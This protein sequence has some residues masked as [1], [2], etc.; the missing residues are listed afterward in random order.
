MPPLL[1]YHIQ[2]GP[3]DDH[4]I[5]RSQLI[6]SQ[7]PDIERMPDEPVFFREVRYSLPFIREDEKRH[8][9]VDTPTVSA[10][11]GDSRAQDAAPFFIECMLVCIWFHVVEHLHYDVRRGEYK[12]LS[13]T[14]FMEHVGKRQG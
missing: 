3:L 14:G 9:I 4:P 7:L 5:G 6:G 8:A 1:V 10:K 13:R 2:Y 12:C 11:C